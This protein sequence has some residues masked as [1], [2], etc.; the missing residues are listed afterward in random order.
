MDCTILRYK[1][2]TLSGTASCSRLCRTRNRFRKRAWKNQ[3]GKSNLAQYTDQNAVCTR[4]HSV[5]ATHLVERHSRRS[6]NPDSPLLHSRDR[7]S[8]KETRRH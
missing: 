2:R 3:S 1:F 7:S 8:Y 5:A 4:S 6:Q